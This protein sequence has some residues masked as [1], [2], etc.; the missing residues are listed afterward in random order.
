MDFDKLK[1]VYNSINWANNL[2]DI[3][4]VTG[5]GLEIMD[6]DKYDYLLTY[7]FPRTLSGFEFGRQTKRVRGRY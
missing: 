5:G 1:L 6:T 3:S 2:V 7:S 4:R